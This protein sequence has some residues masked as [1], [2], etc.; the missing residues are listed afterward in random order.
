MSS[1]IPP[2]PPVT[3]CSFVLE[4]P[5][6][7]PEE[8]LRHF[9]LRLAVETDASDVLTDLQ[10]GKGGFVVVDA[11]SAAAHA[12]MHVPGALSLP[13]RSIDAEAV[14][15]LRDRVAV[16]YCWNQACN[17]G[18]KA[19]ARLAA[20]GIPVKD[21]LGGLE[22]WVHEGNPVESTLPPGTTF[23]QYLR[24]HHAGRGGR[25]SAG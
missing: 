23:E 17:A 1:S 19:A 13:Y 7:S 15:A 14:A 18:A 5:A 10:R 25:Y 9:A 6:A 22:A 11:R 20:L 16:V 21:L 8:A 4:T 2:N 24:W 12:D 3:P